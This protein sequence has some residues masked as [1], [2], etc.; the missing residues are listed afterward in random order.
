MLLLLILTL[1]LGAYASGLSPGG[2]WRDGSGDRVETDRLWSW[3]GQVEHCDWGSATF[4]WIGRESVPGIEETFYGQYVQDPDG[5]FDDLL[6]DEFIASI[7]LPEDA[8]FTGYSK[9]RLRLWIA[10]SILTAVFLEIEGR[11]P[12]WP[13]VEGTDPILCA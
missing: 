12:Q 2:S 6:A 9:S 10:P 8:E 5:L 11:F 13:R 7:D 1:S 3:R 4:L